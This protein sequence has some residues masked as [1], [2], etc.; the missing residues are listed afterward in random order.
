MNE[1]R[2]DK[3]KSISLSTRLSSRKVD[4]FGQIR[5]ISKSGICVQCPA[6]MPQGTSLNINLILQEEKMVC[7]TGKVVW[8]MESLFETQPGFIY[9]IK[10][11]SK[12]LTFDEC[13]ERI[14]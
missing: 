6:F 12:P 8:T 11:V 10:F 1:R 7:P 5:D 2:R 3:R 9:G 13:I 4:S 14:C